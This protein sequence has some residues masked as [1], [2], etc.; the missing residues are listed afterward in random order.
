MKEKKSPQLILFL[1]T[2][3]FGICIAVLSCRP[4]TDQLDETIVPATS[5]ST[6]SP[7]PPSPES[8]S[9]SSHLS[10]PLS[11]SW[12]EIAYLS[13]RS[14][15]A[16]IWLLDLTIGSE[17]QL[18][19]A[20]CSEVS[21]ERLG[22]EG[23]QPGVD[24]F[25][26][27]PDGR[28]IAYLTKCTSAGHMARLSVLDLE[29]GVVVST[30]NHV[31]RYSYPSWDPSGNY[32]IFNQDLVTTCD[33]YIATVS[34]SNRLEVELVTKGPWGGCF[35]CP[36]W[37]PD[38]EFVA[39]RG[40]FVGTTSRT[41]VSISD[42]KGN[43]VSYEPEPESEYGSRNTVWIATP[44][45]AGLAWSSSG[46]YLAVA[47]TRGD[48]PGILKLV[49][50]EGQTA[51]MHV[52]P[53]RYRPGKPFGPDFY[54][55]V[56]SPDDETLYFVST[57]P[58]TE[59]GWPLGTIYSIQVH[60]LLLD[61]PSPDVQTIS[62]ETQLAGLPALSPDGNWLLY[63]VREREVNEIWIQAIDGSYR[64]RLVGDSFANT[65]PAWRP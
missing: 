10:L 59:Y 53:S 52:G 56:F 24:R 25:A 1:W 58:N 37:S 64:Q 4:T 6:A 51:T 23:Y 15:L 26:W 47:S 27:S 5:L 29:T 55:P 21:I 32:F 46:R 14:G 39:Y 7:L 28:R 18:T 22:P 38:G 54:N 48:F 35:Y 33:M 3:L 30:T 45:C 8:T 63:V 44:D 34:D 11:T 60:D 12:Q 57:W 62:S 13:N 40:P 20:D 61:K 16:E 42:L 41:Y 65:R 17:R 31:D 36:T 43:Q 49:E 9:R 50:I 19:M 2:L